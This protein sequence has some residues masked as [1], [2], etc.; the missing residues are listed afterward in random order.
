[1]R[2]DSREWQA[3]RIIEVKG[4]EQE[5]VCCGWGCS[6]AGPR[7][8][9]PQSAVI[10]PAEASLDLVPHSVRTIGISL[11]KSLITQCKWTKVCKRDVS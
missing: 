1:M 2:H 3:G 8:K 4:W 6:R 7:K 9:G 11:I 10:G 5:R